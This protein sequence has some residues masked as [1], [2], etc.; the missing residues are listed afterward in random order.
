MGSG[1]TQWDRAEDK[2]GLFLDCLSE[3]GVSSKAPC[4]LSQ[5][6]VRKFFTWEARQNPFGSGW[7]GWT[8]LQLS[9]ELQISEHSRVEVEW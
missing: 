6:L 2:K 1:L 9:C 8:I 4:L 7:A 3:D 5:V